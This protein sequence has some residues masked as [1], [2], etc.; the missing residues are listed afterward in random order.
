[1]RRLVLEGSLTDFM[2]VFPTPGIENVKLLEILHFLS[3]EPGEFS[4]IARI[5]FYGESP[6]N[7]DF[8][9][10]FE[11]MQLLDQEKGGSLIYFLKK[12]IVQKALLDAGGFVVPPSGIHGDTV[13]F[14]FIGN[15]KQV[16]QFLAKIDVKGVRYKLISLADAKFAFDS[17]LN[18]L[19][20]KQRNAI[21][22]AFNSGYFDLPRRINSE[23]LAKKLQIHHSALNARLRKAERYLLAELLK[24]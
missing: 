8:F 3:Q 1:M 5:A 6:H 11:E 14:A 10:G 9:T 17:P 13:R 7:Q 22:V 16:D 12:K 20:E 2:S 4:V 19:T 23:Q 21:I 24:S 15:M 18:A